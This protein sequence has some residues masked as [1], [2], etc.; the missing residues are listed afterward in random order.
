MVWLAQFSLSLGKYWARI[1]ATRL[2]LVSMA[3]ALQYLPPD[4]H[5]T[6]FG[7]ALATP[8]PG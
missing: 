4:G 3:P 7:P 8:D 6:V 1:P 2:P 5:G